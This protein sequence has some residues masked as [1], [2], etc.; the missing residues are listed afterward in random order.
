MY[1]VRKPNTPYA[2]QT[3]TLKHRV[4]NKTMPTG[5]PW[6]PDHEASR[7]LSTEPKLEVDGKETEY[8]RKETEYDKK[9]SFL[10]AKL[11]LGTSPEEPLSVKLFAD[12]TPLFP[13]PKLEDHTFLT[14]IDAQVRLKTLYASASDS[15]L[16]R[17][18]MTT[19]SPVRAA[20]KLRVSQIIPSGP[21]FTVPERVRCVINADPYSISKAPNF[22][23]DH[24]G[25]LPT[26]QPRPKTKPRLYVSG[27]APGQE[28]LQHSSLKWVQHSLKPTLKLKQDQFCLNYAE[29]L[30]YDLSRKQAGKL[31][32]V[33]PGLVY[34]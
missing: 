31:P 4:K 18:S 15:G 30:H 11:V 34:K 29:Y 20:S 10:S 24:A 12:D 26:P 23:R 8:D 21:W 33:K 6:V 16:L 28:P 27:Q 9:E 17:T 13:Q 22:I 14:S 25:L 7:A 5:I 3:L 2:V 32:G 1:V 19:S